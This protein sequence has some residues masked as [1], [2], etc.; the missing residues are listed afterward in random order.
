MKIIYIP[1]WF[2]SGEVR[3]ECYQKIEEDD[4]G[5]HKVVGYVDD[6]GNPFTLPEPHEGVLINPRAPLLD[7]P[8]APPPEPPVLGTP[9]P[10]AGVIRRGQ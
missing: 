4:R 9:L 6:T 7:L 3:G 2:R 8:N 1:F 10:N 5:G